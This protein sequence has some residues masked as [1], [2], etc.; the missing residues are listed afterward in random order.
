MSGKGHRV[1]HLKLIQEW[2]RNKELDGVVV[3]STDEFLREFT[4]PATRR[5]A[6]ATGFTGSTGVAVVA[7]QACALFLDGRYDEQGRVETAGA[8]ISVLPPT[9]QARQ[10][11]LAAH[12]LQGAVLGVDARLQSYP[13]VKAWL[14][15]GAA[16][17][18]RVE[19]L[20]RHPVDDLWP[21]DERPAED[22]TYVD[23]P[24][25]FAGASAAEKCAELR[26]DLRRRGLDG[27]L[28]SDPDDVAWLLNVRLH[29]RH[30][31]TGVGEW[32]VV[33]SCAS[34][35][36]LA[37]DG[38]VTWFVERSRV[39]E[40]LAARGD[41]APEVVAPSRLPFDLHEWAAGRR[42]AANLRRTPYAL[43]ARIAGG[44]ALVD[45]DAVAR[46]RWRKNASEVEW[47]RAAHV[48]DAVAVV[49]FMAWLA[50]AVQRRRVTELDAA[51]RLVELREKLPECK[52]PS[53]PLLSASGPSGALPHYVPRPHTER[54]V[55]EHPIYWMDSGGQYLGGST[56]NTLTM[57]VGTPAPRHVLAH[58]LVLKG[59]V[60][61]ARARFPAGTRSGHL[62][63]LARQFLWAHGMDYGHGTGHGVGSYL[64]IHEGPAFTKDPL[65]PL[66]LPLEEGMILSNEPAYYAPGDFGVRIESHMVVV[67]SQID[68]YLEFDTISRLPI[69]PNLVDFEL[70]SDEER[71]WLA[72]YHLAVREAL[73]PSLDGEAAAW[74]DR[75]VAAF[76]GAPPARR[77]RRAARG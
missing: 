71:R 49:R 12:L 33:P 19:L 74:L 29:E 5:L 38:G 26:A 3:P 21:A 36:L 10:E 64:N 46:R 61:L 30:L 40:V 48:V 1:S 34:T 15:L 42:I 18:V 44:G 63:P 56:D 62:D 16:L 43:A 60:A 65:S 53:M 22:V 14:E 25:R 24:V 57:A 58:T 68:G 35:V 39:A 69:D 13:D 41:G 52:G 6:W 76:T 23:Y 31:R 51:R 77:R 50:G 67:A 72:E 66:N 9:P 45:D 47:A 11:W 2:M 70:L 73:R 7:R 8:D 54:V 55:N 37:A 28:V 59:Y 75:L 27:C 17:G 32:H 20:E 4:P